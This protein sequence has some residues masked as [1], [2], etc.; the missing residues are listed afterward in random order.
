MKKILALLLSIGMMFSMTACSSS[1]SSVSDEALAKLEESIQKFKEVS[2]ANYEAGVEATLDKEDMKISVYGGFVTETENPLQLNLAMDMESGGRK[3]EK[4]I[5]LFMKDNV[6]Y[7]NLMDLIKQKTTLEKVKENANITNF[8][9]G[10]DIVSIDKE[11][12]KQYL[13]EVSLSGNNLKLSFDVDKVNKRVKEEVLKL[14]NTDS[15]TKFKKLDL[16][17]TLNNDFM[18]KTVIFMDLTTTENGIK[19]ELSSAISLIMKDINN[20]SQL[21]FPDFSDYKEGSILK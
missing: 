13:R 20:V 21:N 14:G 12:M 3:I 16:D 2:S 15:T 17:I 1:S 8:A 18:E 9:S 10:T 6:M 4:Y 5:Q 19:Q 7:M 11:V